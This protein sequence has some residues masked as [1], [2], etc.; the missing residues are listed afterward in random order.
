MESK[1]ICIHRNKHLLN[2]S[3]FQIIRLTKWIILCS[4]IDDFSK[5]YRFY[6]FNEHYR[7]IMAFFGK[8]QI[9]RTANE[10]IRTRLKKS[11]AQ[12][13]VDNNIS[14]L[15]EIN[16]NYA[17]INNKG[18]I[19]LPESLWIDITQ[20]IES[21]M[22]KLKNIDENGNKKIYF[23]RNDCSYLTLLPSTSWNSK[24]QEEY[25]SSACS[26]VVWMP[27]SISE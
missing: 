22:I 26:K 8:S 24:A 14:V 19:L 9:K 6:F 5:N 3:V 27:E 2:I 7:R 4:T 21:L 23:S 25:F 12:K 1:Y 20:K 15:N 11:M 16:Y 10:N 13:D 18:I 17:R